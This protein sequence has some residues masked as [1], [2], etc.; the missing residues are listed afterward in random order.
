MHS[1]NCALLADG[2]FFA[3][4]LDATKEGYGMGLM[5]QYKYMML[6]CKADGQASNKYALEC[7]YI[8][9]FLY[10]PFFLAEIVRDL[11][12]IMM[13]TLKGEEATTFPIT[14]RWNTLTASSRVGLEI[15]GPM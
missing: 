9:P 14:W 6:Y 15:L 8:N 3:N 11:F 13:S 2:L 10:N 12:G 7:L 1:Y 5:R 4:F